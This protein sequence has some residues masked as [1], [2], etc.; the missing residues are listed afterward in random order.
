[1]PHEI[2]G[3]IRIQF[4]NEK[5]T[6]FKIDDKISKIQKVGASLF[7]FGKAIT[8]VNLIDKTQKTF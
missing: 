3:E 5:P 1:M 7:F 8:T 2:N 6:T 4:E